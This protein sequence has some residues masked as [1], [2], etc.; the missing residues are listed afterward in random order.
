MEPIRAPLIVGVISLGSGVVL[1]LA[2]WLISQPGNTM[3]RFMH[4][5]FFGLGMLLSITGGFLAVCIGLVYLMYFFMQP[6]AAKAAK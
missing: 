2:W 4:G 5:L 1:L 6:R 3:L